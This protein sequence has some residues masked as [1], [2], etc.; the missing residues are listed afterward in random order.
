MYFSVTVIFTVGYGNISPKS[1]ESRLYIIIIIFGNIVF[2]GYVMAD[3]TSI[4]N[5]YFVSE[6]NENQKK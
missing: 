5:I 1:T 2:F 6:R 4:F 3:L